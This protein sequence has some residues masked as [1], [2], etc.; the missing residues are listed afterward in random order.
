MR[1]IRHN[2]NY[3]LLYALEIACALFLRKHRSFQDSSLAFLTAWHYW[4]GSSRSAGPAATPMLYM[5]LQTQAIS[6]LM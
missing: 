3:Y 1:S 4:S 5:L 6:P 2:N